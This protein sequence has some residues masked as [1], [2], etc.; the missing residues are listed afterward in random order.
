MENYQKVRSKVV[1]GSPEGPNHIAVGHN[2]K[3]RSIISRSLR[4][5]GKESTDEKGNKS[6]TTQMD[7]SDGEH[8]EPSEVGVV[9]LSGV[10]KA[11]TKAISCAEILKQK[12]KG[13]EQNVTVQSVRIEDE[14][15]ARPEIKEDLDIIRVTRE[16]PSIVMRMNIPKEDMDTT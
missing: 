5:L 9:T 6:G 14:Y 10:G 1:K 11:V 15:E 2:A 13:L 16:V 12:V 8:V 3:I 7:A 4:F